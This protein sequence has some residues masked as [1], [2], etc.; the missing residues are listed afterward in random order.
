[1]Q[2]EEAV[3]VADRVAIAP[4]AAAIVR[5]ALGLAFEMRFHWETKWWPVD[6]QE[7]GQT[8]AGYYCNMHSC[9]EQMR[10]GVELSSG[11][12]FFRVRR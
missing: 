5:R 12:A 6:A 10:E 1:M 7:V 11:L 9:L 4:E 8:L 2:V 3:G